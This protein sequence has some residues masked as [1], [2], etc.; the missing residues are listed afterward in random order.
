MKLKNIPSPRHSYAIETAE[1]NSLEHHIE[2]LAIMVQAKGY[3]YDDLCAYY[4]TANDLGASNADDL[5]KEVERLEHNQDMLQQ[6][7]G[8]LQTAIEWIDK[9]CCTSELA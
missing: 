5:K 6:A 1:R 2:D 7:Y 9:V 8:A 3:E 4:R